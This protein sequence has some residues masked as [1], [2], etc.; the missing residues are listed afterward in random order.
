MLLNAII[1]SHCVAV[2]YTLTGPPEHV[3]TSR[4]LFVCTRS[5]AV[6]DRSCH[7]QGQYKTI[8]QL[9]KGLPL[10]EQ[11]HLLDTIHEL[12][13]ASCEYVAINGTMPQLSEQPTEPHVLAVQPPPNYEQGSF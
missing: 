1:L 7:I 5:N 9:I 10:R 8:E 11:A 13:R 6:D 12:L 4:I 2:N 3:I